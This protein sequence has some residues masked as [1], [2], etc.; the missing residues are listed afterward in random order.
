MRLG[1]REASCRPVCLLAGVKE[2]VGDATLLFI[3]YG[4][5]A[6]DTSD[7]RWEGVAYPFSARCRACDTEKP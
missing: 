6:K 2:T 4:A 3:V 7:G 5:S 1:G